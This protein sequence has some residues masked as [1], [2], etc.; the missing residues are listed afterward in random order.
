MT[1]HVPVLLERILEL[2]V[3]ALA[4]RSA[5]LVDAT[6]GLGG[7][8]DALL[9]AHPD[10]TG[11]AL[12]RDPDALARSAERLARHGDRVRF[13]HAVYDRLP[14]VLAG[15]GLSAVD[16]VLFDLGVSSMQLDLT[17]RGFSYARD[18]P[19]DMRM[20]PTAG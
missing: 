2:F 19:L 18:A 14:E 9:S 1:K 12:D 13:A 5:V 6:V 17:D 3:P 16:G 4:G 8:S 11:V 20:D 10:L 15:F 7:H